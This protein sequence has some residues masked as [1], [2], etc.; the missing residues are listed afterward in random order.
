VDE[1]PDEFANPT[2]RGHSP[3]AAVDDAADRV[4]QRH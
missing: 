1:E 4:D 2:R 3:L